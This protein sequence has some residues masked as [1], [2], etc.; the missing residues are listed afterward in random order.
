MTTTGTNRYINITQKRY[1]PDENIH[2]YEDLYSPQR[3]ICR[4]PCDPAITLL[5]TYP[6]AT[7]TPMYIRSITHS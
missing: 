5:V 3:A 6:R 7:C 2:L 1:G 4:V